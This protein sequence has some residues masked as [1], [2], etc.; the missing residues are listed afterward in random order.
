[1]FNFARYKIELPHYQVFK[2]Q[3][4]ERPHKKW[5]MISQNQ[6]KRLNESN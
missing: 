2:E 1:M 6:V 5:E 4:L 3:F